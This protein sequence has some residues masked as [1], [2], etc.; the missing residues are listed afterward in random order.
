M[1]EET[2]QSLT[3]AH[4]RFVGSAYLVLAVFRA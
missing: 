1:N 3:S 2:L 4:N